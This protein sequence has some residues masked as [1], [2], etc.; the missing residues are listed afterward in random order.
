M[1]PVV[2][3]HK[4]DSEYLPLALRQAK[5]WNP[6]ITLLGDRSNWSVWPRW[7]NI[8]DYPG[9]GAL[10]AYLH[11]SSNPAEFE[12][13]CFTRWFI[14][15]DFAT[16]QNLDE[17]FYCDSDVVLYCDV[18]EARPPGTWDL[19]LAM[20][21]HQPEYRW[22]AAGHVSYWPVSTLSMFCEF[23]ERTYGTKKGLET[24][25]R[26]W[27]WHQKTGKPGGICD[28]TLLWLFARE[29]EIKILTQ[30]RDGRVFDENIN[31]PENRFPSEYRMRAGIKEITWREGQPHGFN[32]LLNEEIRFNALH[33]QGSAKRLINSYARA[34]S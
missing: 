23:V 32:L 7:H 21:H 24:L 16:Y 6:E 2:F 19:A 18:N 26:K 30:V 5:A 28:M 3:I 31:I 14:L 8:T 9:S 12:K 4:G 29:H 13:F 10:R 25:N 34:K 15:R 22:S 17:V 33:F 20:A 1:I 11:M 27:A